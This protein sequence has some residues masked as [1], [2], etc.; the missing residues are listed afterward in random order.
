MTSFQIIYSVATNEA[1]STSSSRQR[2]REKRALVED[3]ND[4]NGVAA[5]AAEVGAT[6]PQESEESGTKAR[7]ETASA[8]CSVDAVVEGDRGVGGATG[9]AAGARKRKRKKKQRAAAKDD[10]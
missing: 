2:L 8:R 5:A 10:E 6:M 4:T 3:A 7:Q 9:L 1:I